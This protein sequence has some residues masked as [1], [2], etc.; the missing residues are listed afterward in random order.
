MTAC[1]CYNGS[2]I[3]FD[4]G[5]LFPTFLLLHVSFTYYEAL[6]IKQ[7]LWILVSAMSVL[8]HILDLQNLCR[9]CCQFF[10][11]CSYCIEKQESIGH[12][13][14]INVKNDN[15][16]LHPDKICQKCYC[17]IST[18]IKSKSTITAAFENWTEL[19]FQQCYTSTFITKSSTWNTKIWI[20]EK[21]QR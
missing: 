14:L 12:I 19:S 10:R 11:K 1:G 2:H 13:F 5:E 4:I 17:V 3:A 7:Q 16:S 18:T 8:L 21:K 15:G 6:S 20:Q 9:I